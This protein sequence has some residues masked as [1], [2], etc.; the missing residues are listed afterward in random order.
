[1]EEGREKLNR[2]EAEINRVEAEIKV[3]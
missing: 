3:A 2:V 1:V